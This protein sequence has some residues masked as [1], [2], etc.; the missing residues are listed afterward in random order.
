[1]TKNR[2]RVVMGLFL[3]L[4]LGIFSSSAF[5]IRKIKT[6]NVIT[7]GNVKVQLINHTL[8]E[9]GKE[10]EVKDGKEELLIYVDVSRIIKVKN[11]CNHPVY[12][13]VKLNTTGKKNQEIFPAEDYV[14]YKFADEKWREKDGW[15]YYTDVLEPN[16]TTEDLMRGIEF[17]VNRLTSEYA[18]SDIE[19]KAEV[20]AV[21]SENNSKNVFAVEGWPEEV[22]K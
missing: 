10:V 17:D 5:L 21:Q 8:D 7:F 2:K 15:I 18:G 9:N 11:V 12:V 14:N 1:M 4:C 20:Q 22:A 6:D 3:I 13:R 16:K 19:F